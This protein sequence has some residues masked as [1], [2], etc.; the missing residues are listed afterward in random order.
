MADRK[1]EIAKGL[2]SI[3]AVF[4]LALI[5]IFFEQTLAGRVGTHIIN[6]AREEKRGKTIC[7][8]I[9]SKFRWKMLSHRSGEERLFREESLSPEW[10]QC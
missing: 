10:R 1:Q 5:H 4:L 2:L 6:A 9:K 8:H 3:G 7:T